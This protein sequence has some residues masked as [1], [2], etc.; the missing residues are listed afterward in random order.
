MTPMREGTYEESLEMLRPITLEFVR[1]AE[2]LDEDIVVPEHTVRVVPHEPTTE[3]SPR[4][5]VYVTLRR[6]NEVTYDSLTGMFVEQR[7]DFTDS[8]SII[9]GNDVV[10]YRRED[11]YSRIPL[12]RISPNCNGEIDIFLYGDRV[13]SEM[14]SIRRSNDVRQFL[15]D[16]PELHPNTEPDAVPDA[17]E[18]TLQVNITFTEDEVD[19]IVNTMRLERGTQ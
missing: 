4:S 1:E 5:R 13:Q 14:E 10:L 9:E 18:N 16:P 8:L 19:E 11:E 17:E 3:R 6:V 12:I 2:A 15:P 7:V